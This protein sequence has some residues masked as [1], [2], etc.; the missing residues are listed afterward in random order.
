MTIIKFEHN[1][2]VALVNLSRVF[3]INTSGSTIIFFSD[4]TSSVTYTLTSATEVLR[5]RTL[6]EKITNS[7]DLDQLTTQ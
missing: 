3:R 7:I 4:A 6:I 2:G 1:S 5:L